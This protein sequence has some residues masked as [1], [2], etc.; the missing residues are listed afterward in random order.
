MVKTG[1]YPRSR[2][3]S[4]PLSGVEL[5]CMRN[6]LSATEERVY[7]KDELSRFLLVSAG[8]LAAYVPGRTAE[9][10]IGKTDFD[11]FGEQSA[12]PKFA[13]EQQIIRTGEPIVGKVERE[14]FSDR[15]SAWVATT[16]MPLRDES[17]RII[18]TFGISRDVTAQITAEKALT[19]RAMQDP[20][21]GLANRIALM[22]RL[23]QA[24]LA[25]ER[26][27]GGLAVLYVDLDHFKNINDAFGHEAGDQVLAEVGRRLSLLA[28]HG[29]TVARLGGDEFVVLCAALGGEADVRLIADRIVTGLRAPYVEDG[30]D[31]STSCSVGIFVTCDCTAEPNQLVHDADVA[32]YGAK[33]EGRNRYRLSRSTQPA[34]AGTGALRAELV[35]AIEGW[36]LFLLYQP[37]FCLETHLLIGVEALVR[38]RHPHRGVV[39][40]HDFIPFA[41]ENGLIGQIDSFVL[42]EACRQLSEWTSRDG[43]PSRF[44]ISVNVSGHELS[45]PDFVERV[46]EVIRR[47]GIEPA[48]L[49]LELTETAFIGEFGDVEETLSGLSA[50]GLRLA[51][52]DFGTG[53]SMLAHLQRLNVDILKI[54]QSLVAQVS[55]SPR[56]RAVVA[57]VT[58]MAH[59]LGITVVGEA[60]ET[61]LQLD[62][63]NALQCDEGQGFI[64]ARPLPPEEVVALVDGVV[65]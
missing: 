13:D 14:T 19:I 2:Q 35:R 36:E 18:G 15:A 9:E 22:D 11:V 5:T 48:R 24:L 34:G 3:A 54:D 65:H 23:S 60:I 21:T 49:C 7:F 51:L 4:R 45:T 64:L 40:P 29:D 50:L 42:N 41:E 1:L 52:D 62:A 53:Y 10:L 27:P 57:A 63:L 59:A 55:G 44:T 16:K 43:W 6:L 37:L 30:R 56:A 28:R 61:S 31:L 12:A 8:W 25:L 26:H 38:W 46:A 39:P 47:H 58:A 20:V 32:M 17:G 33:R